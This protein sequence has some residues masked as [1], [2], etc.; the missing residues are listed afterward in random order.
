[1]TAANP[2]KNSRSIRVLIRLSPISGFLYLMKCA[3][4]VLMGYEFEMVFKN[5]EFQDGHNCNKTPQP[6]E[7]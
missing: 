7:P 4:V 6:D 2:K 1:M 3:F 5:P